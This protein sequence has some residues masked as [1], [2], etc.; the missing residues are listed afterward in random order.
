MNPGPP[1]NGANGHPPAAGM[2][3]DDIYFTLFR[4]KNLILG[5]ALLGIL[6]AV[7]VRVVKPPLYKSK[8]E[9]MVK[10]VVDDKMGGSSPA[11]QTIKSAD[12]FGQGIMNSEV[13]IV[14]SLDIATHVATI[15][16]PEKVLAKLGGGSNML[17][18]A[19][20]ITSGVDVEVPM[21]TTILTITFKHLD[22]TVV[23]PVLNEVIETY[24]FLHMNVHAN[25]GIN[26]PFFEEQRERAHKDLQEKEAEI[27]NL[28]AQAKIV[29]LADTKRS[30]QNQLTRWGDDLEAAKIELAEREAVL[31][32][33]AAQGLNTQA[34]NASEPS[35]PRDALKDYAEIGRNLDAAQAALTE[36]YVKQNLAD[37]HPAVQNIREHIAKFQGQKA[38]LE[39]KYPALL[40]IAVEPV[41]SGTNGPEV[42][43]AMSMTE[44][45]RLK[46]R[47]A[48]LTKDISDTHDNAQRLSDLEGQVAELRRARD[49]AETNY[50]MYAASSLRTVATEAGKEINISVVQNPSPPVRD[51]A[52]V[53]KLAGGAFG[54]CLALG[55]VIAFLND[56]VFDRTVRRSK[57]VERHL[58]L[59]VFLSIPDT[60]WSGRLR[61]PF[62][63]RNSAAV[64]AIYSAYR[65]GKLRLPFFGKDSAAVS[66]GQALVEANGANG[67]SGANG[68]LEQPPAAPAELQTYN[69]GLRERLVTYFEVHNLNLKK[70]KLVGVTGCGSGSG[71]TTLASGLAAELSKTGDGNVLLVDMNGSQGVAH[72]FHKGKP[73]CGLSDVLEPGNRADAQVQEKLYLACANNGGDSQQAKPLPTRFNSIVPKLKASDYDYIIFDMPPVTPTSAT[74]RL[75]S[76]MDIVLLVLESEKTG[77]QL[78]VRATALMREARANVAA[79]L[80]KCRPHVPARLSQPL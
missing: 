2:T 17:A 80:N 74:P 57:D 42:G 71:V 7:A 62:F 44:I 77:Q 64:A 63:D 72:P 6:G 8:A 22:K 60:S 18:A 69:E 76:H 41:A 5:F 45:K 21:R 20:V 19:G 39:R 14:K 51:T 47:I 59:P 36:L 75:S 3:L 4:H 23:Q 30:Y 29:D 65:S 31:P 10:Y 55:L 24:K 43:I 1:S 33:S 52:Q 67:I 38:D 26:K 70:P 35:L 58:R 34:T 15:I 13:E 66:A 49:Q 50:Q 54:G 73:G 61:L 53:M 79:V 56:F 32:R 16:G 28:M 68:S 46:V 78:A 27:R 48:T 37:G 40:A 11:D 25:G 12:P 9:L